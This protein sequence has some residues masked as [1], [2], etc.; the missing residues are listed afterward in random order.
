MIKNMFSCVKALHVCLSVE[1]GRRVYSILIRDWLVLSL[2]TR[3]IMDCCGRLLEAALWLT[4]KEIHRHEIDF[5]FSK[6]MLSFTHLL[7]IIDIHIY[8][9]CWCTCQETHHIYNSCPEHWSVEGFVILHQ[10]LC[11]ILVREWVLTYV[12][13]LSSP[14][15]P[16]LTSSVARCVR[17]KAL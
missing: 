7:L 5:F 3:L 13:R 2:K 8:L 15:P 11:F 16:H 10:K 17:V 9:H 6:W 14:L 1:R 12:L 4:F